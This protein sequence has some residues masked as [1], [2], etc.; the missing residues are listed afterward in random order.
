[1]DNVRTQSVQSKKGKSVIGRLLPGTDLI[2]GIE[3]ICQENRID[4]GTIITVIGS[5][6]HAEIGYVIPDKNTRL[7]VKY[8]E[9]VRVEGPLELLSGQGMIGQANDGKLSIHLHG[10]MSGPDMK[11]FGGHFVE[12]GNPTLATVE[13]MTQEN[14]DIQMLREHDEETGFT[15]FNFYQKQR[16]GNHDPA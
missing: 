3:K 8:V 4:R 7:G 2:K 12:N 15:L 14:P 1:M 6:V 11:V 13:I 16:G 5:L 10:L 9:P